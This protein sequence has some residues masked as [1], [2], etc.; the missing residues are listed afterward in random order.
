MQSLPTFDL[1]LFG[2]T[3]DLAMRK[4]LPALYRRSCAGQIDGRVPHHR[5]GAQRAVAR[6]V[7][8]AGARQLRDA[9]RQRLR[10]A[11]WAQFA[12]HLAVRARS[13]PQSDG[14]FGA[15]R[16]AAARPRRPRARV[17]PLDRARTC[18]RRSARGWRD[19]RWSRRPRASCWRSRS[20]T[21][22]PPRRRSTSASASSSPSSRSFASITTS[23]RRR[24]RTCWRCASATAVRAAVAPRPHSAR[25]DHRRRGS[26]RR[27]A[28]AVLR[29]D[30]RAARHG[31]EPPAAA[32]VH[33]RDGAAGHRRP[34]TRCATRS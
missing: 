23:A 15:A 5:R 19:S 14:D 1:V 27:A 13:T 32:P 7:S 34:P 31:A 6:G 25:A 17:L 3:G 29:S 2:G 16:G 10:S 18:S 4:L 30:R 11:K 24:C 20:A 22:A 9:P 12:E 33:H 26:R 8:G 28:R 21:T